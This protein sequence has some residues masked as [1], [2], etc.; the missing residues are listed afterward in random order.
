MATVTLAAGELARQS[1]MP[2]TERAR[3][4]ATLAE[5][6]DE[7]LVLPAIDKLVGE[8]SPVGLAKRSEP[9]A[10]CYAHARRPGDVGHPPR[11]GLAAR[12]T[13]VR[14]DVPRGLAALVVQY[15]GTKAIGSQG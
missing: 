11:S 3:I 12:S 8:G 1:R 5:E 10:E 15:Q 6:Y 14:R 9:V 2:P 7:P 13:N 4:R